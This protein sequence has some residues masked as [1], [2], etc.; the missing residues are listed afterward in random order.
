MISTEQVFVYGTLRRGEANHGL[1]REACWLDG[2]R[3]EPCY[4]LLNL[5]SYPA[6]IAGGTTA[7][8]GE[9]Y[10]INR[11]QLRWL[12][13]LEG[14]PDLYQRMPIDTPHGKAWIYLYR[15]KINGAPPIPSGD[16]RRRPIG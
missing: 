14:H 9:L 11:A 12:D 13:R 5:G 15:R 3:T 4:T 6:A 8:T 10:R 7:L 16:W 2:H 1:L